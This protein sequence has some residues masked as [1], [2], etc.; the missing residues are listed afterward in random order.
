MAGNQL[1]I[2]GVEPLG[3]PYGPIHAIIGLVVL[4]AFVVGMVLYFRWK[5][6]RETPESDGEGRHQSES[7]DED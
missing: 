6:P 3:E 4:V 1:A 5:L 2:P 7:S